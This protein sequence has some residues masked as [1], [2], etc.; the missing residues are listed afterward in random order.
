MATPSLFL[1]RH[2]RTISHFV[3]FA[4]LSPV[5]LAA[6][7]ALP[8]VRGLA[9]GVVYAPDGPTL[10][11]YAQGIGLA[12]LLASDQDGVAIYDNNVISGNRQ[13]VGDEAPLLSPSQAPLETNEQRRSGLHDSLASLYCSPISPADESNQLVGLVSNSRSGADLEWGPRLSSSYLAATFQPDVAGQTVSENGLPTGSESTDHTSTAIPRKGA[14]GLE[15]S[16]AWIEKR[17]NM[18][19]LNVASQSGSRENASRSKIL[20]IVLSLAVHAAVTWDAQ[21][22]NH[23]FHHYPEGYRPF[24]ADPLMRPFAGKALMY[25]MANLLFAAPFDLLAFKTGHSR[26][27]VRMLTYAAGGLWAGLEMRQAIVNIGNEHINS[28]R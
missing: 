17:H 13:R 7:T 5:A 3:V 23:F 4:L 11:R 15:V 18:A 19:F 10:L 22:T 20:P 16:H 1:K 21:S 8:A 2:M 25:P 14:T 6:Q 27:P 28:R 26:K 24:E 9:Q 12:N